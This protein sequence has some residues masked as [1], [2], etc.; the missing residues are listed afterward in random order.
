ME[1]KVSK[2]IE[3]ITERYMPDDW[4][5]M[6][7]SQVSL[8][9]LED[10]I[11]GKFRILL[12]HGDAGTGKSSAARII[13]LKLIGR[14][15]QPINCSRYNRLRED[16]ESI[17]IPKIKQSIALGDK[18]PLVILNE[19]DRLSKD[20]QQLLK[21][22]LEETSSRIIMITNHI[23]KIIPALQSRMNKVFFPRI[24][25]SE[26]KKFLLK[27]V[28][29]EKLKVSESRIDKLVRYSRGDM[30]IALNSLYNP[31]IEIR[32]IS[33]FITFIKNKEIEAA[34]RWS[35]NGQVSPRDFTGELSDYV[36]EHN[37]MPFSIKK[38]LLI[39]I[40]LYDYRLG[41][42]YDSRI[43]LRALVIQFS[44][45]ME[46]YRKWIQNRRNSKL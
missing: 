31:S 9:T 15:L 45:K 3:T 20:A 41:S 14:D 18:T 22:E 34:I 37:K 42:A 27:V 39:L 29:T 28:R 33:Q 11:S 21:Q 5:E 16:V 1:T 46:K 17:L 36:A 44:D 24:D 23:E 38:E 6:V 2:Y 19:F 4:D 40:S 7:I 32:R 12:L 10:F 26:M 8:E 35:T 13:S 30:R 25:R 43:H